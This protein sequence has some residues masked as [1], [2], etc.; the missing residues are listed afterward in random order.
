M[1]RI[2]H[3]FWHKFYFSSWHKH[4][5]ISNSS[6][7]AW[8]VYFSLIWEKILFTSKHFFFPFSKST[9]W[10]CNGIW[11]IWHE[12]MMNRYTISMLVFVWIFFFCKMFYSLATCEWN[13]FVYIVSILVST[14]ISNSFMCFQSWITNFKTLYVIWQF[15]RWI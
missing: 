1:N 15:H 4:I 7:I 9:F 14:C 12:R 3:S 5:S 13:M 2:C 10:T 11:V 6:W 8:V